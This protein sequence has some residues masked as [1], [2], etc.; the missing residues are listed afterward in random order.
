MEGW[1]TFLSL[2][3]GIPM[4]S[5]AFLDT[6]QVKIE[7]LPERK[8]T[9]AILVESQG[10]PYRIQKGNGKAF[11]AFI[12]FRSLRNPNW[13]HFGERNT[14]VVPPGFERFN[15]RLG[16]FLEIEEK[17]LAFASRGKLIRDV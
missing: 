12:G 2:P 9:V 15:L 14:E 4:L 16:V 10:H 8:A 5:R 7:Q 6:G 1:E 13:R 17:L 11:E 3:H